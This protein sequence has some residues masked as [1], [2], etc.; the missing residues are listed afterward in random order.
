VK[1]TVRVKTNANESSVQRTGQREFAVRVKAPAR[2]GKANEAV[3]E[4][5]SEY[6]GCPKRMIS[7]VSGKT[8]RT[9]IINI[10]LK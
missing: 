8:S 6:S 2:E 1:I 4:A 10:P 7:I 3:I 9:K 5:L